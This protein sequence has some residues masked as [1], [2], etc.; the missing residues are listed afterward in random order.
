MKIDD[1]LKNEIDFCEERGFQKTT[2]GVFIYVSKNGMEYMNLPAIL[3]DYKDWLIENNIVKNV[4]DKNL[5][6]F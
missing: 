4:I 6:K 3:N 2:E 5:K 1:L